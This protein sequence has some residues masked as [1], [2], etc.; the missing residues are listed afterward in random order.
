MK[1]SDPNKKGSIYY[2]TD[3]KYINELDQ[4]GLTSPRHRDEQYI[5]ISISGYESK[6]KCEHP[7]LLEIARVYSEELKIAECNKGFLSYK[8]G[9]VNSI[10]CVEGFG[11]SP[12]IYYNSYFGLIENSHAKDLITAVL[13]D[14]AAKNLVYPDKEREFEHLS[15]ALHGFIEE[16]N[17]DY[18]I[19]WIV[20]DEHVNELKNKMATGEMKKREVWSIKEF[21]TFNF[22]L[23]HRSRYGYFPSDVNMYLENINNDSFYF[24]SSKEHL[25]NILQEII[26][27]DINWNEQG[28]ILRNEIKKWWDENQEKTVWD[29]NKYRYKWR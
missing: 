16:I 5:S 9:Y 2:G 15:L 25:K 14:K 8:D 6:S 24:I 10:T 29:S 11:P 12:N 4:F 22:D 20:A 7:E 18:I 26:P 27:N 1:I 21:Q 13:S 23:E 19:G 28:N 17:P 3:N